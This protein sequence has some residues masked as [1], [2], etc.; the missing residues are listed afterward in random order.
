MS[1]PTKLKPRKNPKQE[2]ARQTVE[3]ILEAAAQVFEAMGYARGTTDRIAARAGV[4]VGS[5]YQYFPNK[6]AILVALA[7]RHVEQGTRLA[8]AMLASAPTS[9]DALEPWF[10]GLVQALLAVHR[11]RPRLQG[12]LI[13][14]L[15]IPADTQARMDAAEA[16]II[17]DLASILER[18][19][20]PGQLT[21]PK[22][23]AW[24]LV[25]TIEGLVHE[26]IVH[27][28][29]GMDEGVFVEEM[30]ALAKGRLGIRASPS[31]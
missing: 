29:D 28:L 23:T 27:P 10:R 31:P 3:A 26:F 22:A 13:E 30:V 20:A 8:R 21:S 2:R 16:L 19:A 24:V 12:L 15:P 1:R 9:P 5:L 14:G 7:E 11:S 6:D 4:S 18:L 25:H 17:T